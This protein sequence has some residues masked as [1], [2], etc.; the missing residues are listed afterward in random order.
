MTPPVPRTLYQSVRSMSCWRP[1]GSQKPSPHGVYGSFAYSPA[2]VLGSLTPSPL[3]TTASGPLSQYAPDGSSFAGAAARAEGAVW[4]RAAAASASATAHQRRGEYM[5]MWRLS[6]RG[7]HK[8]VERSST[9][10]Q[11][12]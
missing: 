12:F 10:S 1:L 8:R 7:H 11:R 5:S 2:S 3:A 4:S 6:L 9:R